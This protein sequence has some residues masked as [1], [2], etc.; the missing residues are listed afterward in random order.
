MLDIEKGSG[1]AF[2]LSVGATDLDTDK[3]PQG[4]QTT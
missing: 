2:G 1:P 4:P 3:Q